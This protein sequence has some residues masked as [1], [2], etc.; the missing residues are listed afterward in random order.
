VIEIWDFDLSLSSG[1]PPAVGKPFGYSTPDN[2]RTAFP[3]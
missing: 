3:P 2:G 1:A